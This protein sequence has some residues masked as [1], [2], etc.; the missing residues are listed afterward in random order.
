MAAPAYRDQASNTVAASATSITQTVPAGTQV[1]DL[2]LWAVDANTTSPGTPTWGGSFTAIP[3]TIPV[4]GCFLAVAWKIAVSGDLGNTY[5]VSWTG[6][7]RNSSMMLAYSGAHQTTPIHTATP[8]THAG[9]AGTT[10]TTPGVTTTV[11]DCRVVALIADQNAIGAVTH[12]EP[13]GYAERIDTTIGGSGNRLGQGAA[14][15]AAASAGSHGGVTY[16]KSRSS[17]LA[18]M[19]TVAIAPPPATVTGTAALTGSGT[20]TATGKRTVKGTAAATG[21]G[22]LAA[23]GK[24]LVRGIAALVGSGSLAATGKRR[25][26]GA[27]AFTGD[28]D[29]TATG[30]VSTPSSTVYG[31]AS[32]TGVGTLATTGGRSVRGAV[33]ATGAGLLTA[34]GRRIVRGL[35]TLTGAGT[36]HAIAAGYEPPPTP[37]ERTHTVTAENRVDTVAAE[38]RTHVVPLEDRTSAIKPEDRTTQIP[39]ETRTISI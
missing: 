38:D 32:L 33:T 23:T 14:D 20:L 12:T 26:T 6:S 31:T 15:I 5:S 21:A 10:H 8:G 27:A 7:A 34:A 39:A 19:W 4:D 36:L 30:T 1:G 3:G 9:A 18:A 25:V 11:A 16:T 22:A 28:G 24:R 13:S 35:A 17:D 29:L 37:T 2:L